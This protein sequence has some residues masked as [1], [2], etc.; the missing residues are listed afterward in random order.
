MAAHCPSLSECSGEQLLLL[1][2]FRPHLA[3][4]LEQELQRRAGARLVMA[5]ARANPRAP[6]P[7]RA[8][9]ARAA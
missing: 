8:V 2:I 9:P 5:P 3:A 6:A 7:H 1:R 4:L